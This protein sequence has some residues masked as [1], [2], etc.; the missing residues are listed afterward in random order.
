MVIHRKKIQEIEKQNT[1]LNVINAFN[2]LN[3]RLSGE[4]YSSSVGLITEEGEKV[5]GFVYVGFV[6]GIGICKILYD[7]N[8]KYERYI[9]RGSWFDEH[10]ELRIVDSESQKRILGIFAKTG[11]LKTNNS[12]LQLLQQVR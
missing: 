9:K 11:V 10:G 12:F 4:Y 7:L 3:K 6:A 2:N 1:Y 5:P 8:I